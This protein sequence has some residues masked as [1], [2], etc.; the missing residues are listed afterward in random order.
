[1]APDGEVH[2]SVESEERILARLLN[3][4]PMLR[5]ALVSCHVQCEPATVIPL[6]H[7]RRRHFAHVEH[8]PMRLKSS[9]TPIAA[10]Q[11]E[12]LNRVDRAVEI[13]GLAFRLFGT[14]DFVNAWLASP[15]PDLCRRR[16]CD[17]A[18]SKRGATV[19]SKLLRHQL[20][21]NQEAVAFAE[22]VLGHAAAAWMKAPNPEL[23]GFAPLD[24]LR[25]PEGAEVVEGLL[26][27]IQ[28]AKCGVSP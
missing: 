14:V 12:R 21:A 9:T 27:D 10:W 28:S 24:L 6:Q 16:P 2:R 11:S 23:D 5:R 26:H 17:L 19:V 7:D 25:G 20:L 3:E 4:C 18:F 13:V 8:S 15:N 1:M 22:S